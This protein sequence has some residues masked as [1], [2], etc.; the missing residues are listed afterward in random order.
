MNEHAGMLLQLF[1]ELIDSV[2]SL[3]QRLEAMFTDASCSLWLLLPACI[4]VWCVGRGCWLRRSGSCAGSA[5]QRGRSAERPLW[6][7]TSL[8]TL[9][10]VG[11]STADWQSLLTGE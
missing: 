2:L 3:A 1:L 9:K 10:A 4:V 7:S 8:S 6:C 5:R 11:S